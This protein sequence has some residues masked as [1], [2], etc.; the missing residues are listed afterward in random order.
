M[1]NSLNIINNEFRLQTDLIIEYLMGLKEKLDSFDNTTIIKEKRIEYI[2][3]IKNEIYPIL[4]KHFE[5][6]WDIAKDFSKEEYKVHQKYYQG[7]L[8]PLLS[9]A[10]LNKRIYEKPLGY[11][12][13]FIMMNYYYDDNYEGKSTYEMLLHRYTLELPLARAHINRKR[14]FKEKMKGIFNKNKE[15]VRIA[16]FGCGPAIEVIEFIKENKLPS[17]GVFTFVDAEP[18]ALE[19]IKDKLSEL[20]TSNKFEVKYLPLNIIGLIKKSENYNALKGQD[21]IYAAGLFDYFDNRVAKKMLNA[22][23]SLLANNGTLIIVNVCKDHKHKAYMEIL[24]QWYLHLRDKKE[25]LTLANEIEDSAI[26]KIEIDEETGKNL[27]LVINKKYD[28]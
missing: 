13:D 15:E 1:E 28:N 24:G 4:D 9:T 11:P 26:K 20:T 7:K 12:G 8:L 23:Y 14:Y 27:Y 10:P 25:M 22:L 2:N 6:I 19:Q 17:K 3:N 18:K 21:F 16:S 5:K